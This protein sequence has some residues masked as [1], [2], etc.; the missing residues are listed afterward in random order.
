MAQ[1]N[2]SRYNEQA[3]N[4]I[5][6]N[7]II[8]ASDTAAKD[9]TKQVSDIV[10]TTDNLTKQVTDKILSEHIEIAHWTSVTAKPSNT[11][12]D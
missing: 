9:S 6:L 4:Y 5:Q 11:W 10:F 3:F 8:T 1:Y 7:E 2:T 12:S